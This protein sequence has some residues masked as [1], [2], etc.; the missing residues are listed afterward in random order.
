MNGAQK[1]L[2]DAQNTRDILTSKLME[3]TNKMDSANNQLSEL[4]KERDSLHRTLESLRSEKHL[5]DKEKVE[6][7]LMLE[8]LNGDFEKSQSAK[9]NKQKLNDILI[10]EK[11]ML[12]LD[13]HGAKK[14]K[15]LT[16]MNLRF[17]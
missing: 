9:S 6:L 7:N 14:D 17:V 13:L 2:D 16:E 4:S 12:E 3:L 10:E 8:T 1:Q 11:K 5:L 15:E